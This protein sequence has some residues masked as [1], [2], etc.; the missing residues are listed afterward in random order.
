MSATVGDFILERLSQWGV[1]RIYGYPGDGIN[2]IIGAFDRAGD[3]IKFVQ[4]RHE[5]MAAF[6]AC[7]HA[8]F[9]GEVDVCLATSGP[10]AIHL[11]NGLY[12]AK[13]DHVPVVA[14][15]GQQARAA[16]GGNY[17]QEVNLVSLFKDVAHEYVHVASG[18]AQ[19]RHLIDRAMR[20]AQAERTVTCVIVPNDLQELPAVEQPKRAHG[21]VHSGVGYSKPRVVPAE[22]DL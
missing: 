18:P 22:L 1:D 2:G 14:I 15:V 4:V 6:M 9:T 11:L 12:D 16:I 8:K 5:E 21:T 13:L 7:A 20:I 3:K 17:Q 10:G 19:M